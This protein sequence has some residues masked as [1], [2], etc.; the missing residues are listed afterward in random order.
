[1]DKDIKIADLLNVLRRRRGLIAGITVLGTVLICA[2]PVLLPARYTAKSQI[3]IEP[4]SLISDRNSVVEQS[5]D[6]AVVQ[7]QIAALTAPELLQR[8]IDSLEND[9]AYRAA[10]KQKAPTVLGS[11]IWEKT[12]AM[13]DGWIAAPSPSRGML[14]LRALQRKLHV[15]QETGPT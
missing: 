15:F 6:E 2:V 14:T 4:Q 10:I 8:V 7:T 12:L 1:M 5:P 3:L 13:L 11:S 9:P